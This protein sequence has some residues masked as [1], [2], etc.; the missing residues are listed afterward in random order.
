MVSSRASTTAPQLSAFC[1]GE[2]P[3]T[4]EEPVGDTVLRLVNAMADPAQRSAAAA[5]LAAHWGGQAVLVLIRDPELDVLLPAPGFPRTLP[6]GPTWRDLIAR[7]GRAGEVEGMIGYPDAATL[8]PMRALVDADGS[9]LVLIGGRPALGAADLG[10]IGFPLLSALLRAEAKLE[11]SATL[12][13]ETRHATAR[14]SALAGALDAARSESATK[15]AELARALGEAAGLNDALRRHQEQL[16]ATARHLEILNRIGG[17]ISAELDFEKLVQVVTDAATELTGAQFGA[18]FYNRRDE[19]GDTYTLHTLSGAPREAFAAFPMPRSTA[20]FAPTFRGEGI[21]RSDDI[22]RDPRY[23]RNPP[24]KGMPAGH[25]PV[26]S[27]LAVPVISR[28]GDVL[29]GLFLG[30]GEPGVFDAH[31]EM[32]AVGI[33]A[34]AA[35]AIDNARLYEEAQAEIRERRE[36]EAA[37][38]QSEDRFRTLANLAPAFVWFGAPDG[39]IRYL[40]DRWY[41]YTGQ[42]PEQA[43]PVAAVV[44]TAAP[45]ASPG[46]QAAAPP[47]TAEALRAAAAAIQLAAAALQAAAAPPTATGDAPVPASSTPQ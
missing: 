27:Y 40:N 10:R 16:R 23:G 7:C 38:R 9:V 31:A 34:Q 24:Y 44:D 42:T 5:A 43:L 11:A 2:M 39:G 25:L 28:S 3:S 13:A 47:T 14:A 26:R 1:R 29:G 19:R 21:I 17:L 20:V 4:L 33:A 36:A 12:V 35:I 41:A 8:T 30:H 22:T 32:L 15:A 37:L 46:E 6:G 18:L 45:A